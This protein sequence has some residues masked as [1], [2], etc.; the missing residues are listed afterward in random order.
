M[1]I[2]RWPPVKTTWGKIEKAVREELDTRYYA[3]FPARKIAVMDYL[4]A[5]FYLLRSEVV[6][7]WASKEEGRPPYKY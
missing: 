5:Q 1:S 6:A 2:A 3:N 4:L 7:E